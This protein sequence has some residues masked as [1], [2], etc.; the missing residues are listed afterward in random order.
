MKVM[1]A[2]QCSKNSLAC[3]YLHLCTGAPLPSSQGPGAF[4]HELKRR[5]CQRRRREG[6]LRLLFQLCMP[7]PDIHVTTAMAMLATHHLLLLFQ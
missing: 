5:Q 1:S 2:Q 4:S 6:D 7:A 3:M